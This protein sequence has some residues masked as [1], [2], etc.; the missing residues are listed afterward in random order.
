MM[1]AGALEWVAH[2]GW[3][4][5]SEV[6]P[7][8]LGVVLFVIV[9]RSLGEQFAEALVD[10]A[11]AHIDAEIEHAHLWVIPGR[12]SVEKDHRRLRRCGA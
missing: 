10:G 9:W 7:S 12:C 11:T 6:I 4:D 8:G 3:T 2:T 1:S 5:F